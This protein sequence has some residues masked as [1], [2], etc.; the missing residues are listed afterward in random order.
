VA[1]RV[2]IKAPSI[3]QGAPYRVGDLLPIARIS[4]NGG[5][6][7]RAGLNTETVA[8]YARAMQDGATFPL[9]IVYHDG[10][11]HWLADGFHRA[12][13]AAEI[14]L[15][16][17]RAEVRSGDK[18]AAILYAVGANDTHGLRRT[19]ADKRRAITALLEDEEWRQWSDSAIAKQVKV[20]HK[21]VAS[22]RAEM[23]ATG[24]IPGSSV[25]QSADG[26]ARDVTG[27]AESN[28]SRAKQPARNTPAF[29]CPIGSC[30]AL[31]IA[32]HQLYPQGADLWFCA[33]HAVQ[34]AD[35]RKQ[36]WVFTPKEHGWLRLNHPDL[37]YVRNEPTI[38]AALKAALELQAGY[39]RRDLL[40]A[41][42]EARGG[43]PDAADDS[44]IIATIRA[45]AGALGL[46][47]IWEDDTVILHWPEEDVDQLIGMGY[48][49]ALHWLATE[50]PTQAKARAA[51]PFW[52]SIDAH[53]PTAHLWTRERPD[54]LRS[55]CGMTIQNRLPS[56]RTD[57][58]HCS[59]CT[60]ATWP[61]DEERAPLAIE[62]LDATLPKALQD[63]GYFWQ[64]ATPPILAHND[65]WSVERPL[66]D[67]ALL[68]ASDRERAK[69]EPITVFPALDQAECKRLIREAKQFIE[70]GFG[71]QFPTIG[72]A[73]RIA[74]RMALEAT[75]P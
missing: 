5:T 24:E 42:A 39:D 21:T 47:V 46:G 50:A 13:A 12:A 35:L 60:R 41:E 66:P 23:V 22:V 36:S 27:I 8:E 4:T 74:A 44:A 51:A 31:G 11:D 30:G 15:S 49:D 68:A 19:S 34:I 45:E 26:K 75:E 52:Q 20:D 69:G 56:G 64:S 53:H 9:I 71:S 67:Q 29:I 70:Q 62:S 28:A 7:A 2:E 54:L 55:A 65:G 73:L 63:A 43:M 3:D 17:I 25:R 10:M 57:G 1:S 38:E 33:T 37:S 18:R 72:Q 58:G 61:R 14:G 16:T 6:Q 59:S 40:R 48:E 32:A